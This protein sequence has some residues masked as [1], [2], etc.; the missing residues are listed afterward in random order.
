VL[1]RAAVRFA[2]EFAFI[3]LVAVV[4]AIVARETSLTW[5][6]I[7]LVMLAAWLV[8]VAAEWTVARFGPSPSTAEPELEPPAGNV[9]VVRGVQ[10]ATTPLESQ[11]LL[12]GPEPE[13]EPEPELE[14]AA[15]PVAALEPESPAEP[16]P[17]EESEPEPE[18]QPEPE[19]VSEPAREPE[20]PRLAAVPPAPEPES[21]PEPV[22]EPAPPPVPAPTPI[23]PA[24]PR[25]WNIWD[26]ERLARADAGRDVERDEERTYLL[27]FLR[28]FADADGIL[29]TDFDALVRDSFGDLMRA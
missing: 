29:P 27:M 4:V 15:A 17:E 5:V 1:N 8:V 12:R 19:P 6:G 25:E 3:V 28:D 7:V 22:S 9:D 14:P 26:L 23:A 2:L 16:A 24:G 10:E 11:A 18:A 21:K 13:P 20:P